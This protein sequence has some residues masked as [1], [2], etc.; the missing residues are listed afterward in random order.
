MFSPNA[1]SLSA[2]QRNLNTIAAHRFQQEFPF[3]VPFKVSARPLALAPA[4]SPD[5]AAGAPLI[6]S[7]TFVL[8]KH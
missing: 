2:L 6:F 4:K 8:G 7:S 3:F 1:C 5:D